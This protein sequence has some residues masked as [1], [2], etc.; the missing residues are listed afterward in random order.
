M[1]IIYDRNPLH[2]KIFLDDQEK[3]TF[4][5]KYIAKQLEDDMWFVKYYL[6]KGLSEEDSTKH[7]RE[8]FQIEKYAQSAMEALL[9][10]HIGDCTA[11]PCSCEKCWAE[12]ILGVYIAPPSKMIGNA[13]FHAFEKF[14][15]STNITQDVLT[16]LKEKQLQHPE[17]EHVVKYFVNYS[18]EHLFILE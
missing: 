5:W 7:I 13:I 16:F 8:I 12:D 9:D 3:E 18:K 1:K 2:V 10:Q 4:K 17:Y 14:K 15:S 11:F 6:T